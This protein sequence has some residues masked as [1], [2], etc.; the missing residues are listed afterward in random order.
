ALALRKEF[1]GQFLNLKNP[2]SG[3][4]LKD[5][6]QLMMLET[7]NEKGMHYFIRHHQGHKKLPEYFAAKLGKKWHAFLKKKYKTRDRLAAAWAV[8]D[9]REGL[10]PNEILAEG[11][12][13]LEPVVEKD[14]AFSL[15]RR[16][17]LLDFCFQMDTDHQKTMADHYRGIGYDGISY[18]TDFWCWMDGLDGRWIQNDLT[19]VLEDHAYCRVHDVFRSADLIAARSKI[20][21][22]GANPFDFRKPYARTETRN[23]DG[24][25]QNVHW[26]RVANPLYYAV[27]SS[28]IGRDGVC[29][30]CWYMA[31]CNSYDFTMDQ[32][33]YRREGKGVS[34]GDCLRDIPWQMV[35]RAA[36]RL[37]RS[38][39]I[40][41]LRGDDP[42]LGGLPSNADIQTPHIFR[43]AQ[44]GVL[45]VRT[46][47]F[48]ALAVDHPYKFSTPKLDMDITSD[49]CNVVI[50][51]KLSEKEHEITAVGMA[52]DSVPTPK[53]PL[54]FKPMT[55]VTGTI[56]FKNAKVKSIQRLNDKN[57]LQ[58]T[59]D[60]VDASSVRLVKGTRLY[61]VELE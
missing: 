3:V 9:S 25:G 36:G 54:V 11:T 48:T 60:A 27:Y 30:H 16:E 29:F 32:P 58:G 2:R 39:E 4:A 53:D 12:V 8:P 47:H 52:G 55:W 51:E 31:Q 24:S 57:K 34:G 42:R 61:R 15:K 19:P 45:T 41:A 44:E 38:G 23:A 37:Y 7:V 17:D 59:V 21:A 46:D 6:P 43:S 1:A 20:T 5:D 10:L 33:S 50:V 56:T 40:P 35:Y 28:L 49:K 18:L 13:A 22:P 26:S 14:Y